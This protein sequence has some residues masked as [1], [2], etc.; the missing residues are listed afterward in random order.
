M[1]E[2]SFSAHVCDTSG[3]NDRIEAA[4]FFDKHEK[5]ESETYIYWVFQCYVQRICP[6]KLLQKLFLTPFRVYILLVSPLEFKIL[7]YPF[8]RA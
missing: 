6:A 1:I 3:D 4:K 2:A 8:T 5:F 7:T